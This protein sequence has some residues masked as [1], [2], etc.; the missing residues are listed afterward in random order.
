VSSRVRWFWLWKVE[1]AVEEGWWGDGSWSVGGEAV[2]GRWGH[3][4]GRAGWWE[5][6][7]RGDG[8]GKLWGKTK[9][10]GQNR[11][12]GGAFERLVTSY[13]PYQHCCLF[14]Y[15][16]RCFNMRRPIYGCSHLK[17]AL[18]LRRGPYE[19]AKENIEIG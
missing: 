13:N 18:E 11:R 2:K 19:S 14:E 15:N 9:N 5:C 7:G 3:I 8:G 1:K 12:D 10:R 16:K 17:V 4:G 6:H